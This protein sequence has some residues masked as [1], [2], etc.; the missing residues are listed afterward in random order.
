M[1]GIVDYGMGNLLSVFHGVEMAGGEARI[2]S[3]PEE[4]E[5]VERIILPGVGAFRDCIQ[6]LRQQGFAEA[7]TD[8][9]LRRGKPFFG[10]CLGLQALGRTSAEGGM[11]EGLGWL[12]GDVIRL[13]PSSPEL[14]VP[15]IGWNEVT[16]RTGSPLFVGLPR[17]PE[18][19]FVHSYHLCCDDEEVVEG[20]SDH[21]G[22]VTASVRKDNI[23]ATQFH[24]EK[25]QEYGIKLLENFLLWTP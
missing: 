20:V 24:P 6:N 23:F 16:W 9:V 5:Q 19:Y 4:L 14:R 15:H 12:A 2:C 22:P 11:Y 17:Q 25:S 3:H 13:Q 18:F 21:G 7:L 1:V 8:L 10:I